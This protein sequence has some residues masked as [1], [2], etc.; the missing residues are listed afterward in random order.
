MILVRLYYGYFFRLR[1]SDWSVNEMSNIWRSLGT[2]VIGELSAV[3][4]S[5]KIS[6]V[7]FLA[8]GSE[9]S[10]YLITPSIKFGLT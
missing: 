3:E 4:L 6:Y 8:M 9:E 2:E 7:S 10:L 1:I 5:G